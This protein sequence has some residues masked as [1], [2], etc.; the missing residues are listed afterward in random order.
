MSKQTIN[1]GASPNDGTGTPLRTS[2]D[3]TNQN[4]TELYTA[5]G[6]GVG[7]PGA[8]TQVI[9]NDGGTNLAGDAGL[10]YNK[11]TD[12]LTVAGLVTAGSATITGALTANG[13]VNLANAT[14][15]N[16][17]GL[18]TIYSD[19]AAGLFIRGRTV[20][21]T[22]FQTQDGTNPL[23]NIS[24]A[25][26]FTF[27][28]GA[29]GTRMT[30]NSTGLGIGGSPRTKFDV[31]LSGTANTGGSLA[32]SLGLFTGPG[33]VP[34]ID[35]SRAGANVNIESN[36][37]QGIDVG[38]SL[39]LGGRYTDSST[40][41]SGFAALF[42]AKSTATSNTISGYLAFYTSQ[43]AV[44][45]ERMRI[46]S[47]GNVGIGVTP[48]AWAST[49]KALNVST[50]AAFGGNSDDKLTLV[51]NNLYNDGSG[52]FIGNGYAASYDQ[53]QGA[54]R[55]KVS[56]TSNASGA[57]AALTLTQ[58]MTLDASGR[59]LV[60]STSA[61]TDLTGSKE[62]KIGDGGLQTFSSA[63]TAATATNIARSGFGALVHVAASNATG[64]YSAVVIFT[65]ASATVV[66]VINGTGSTITFGVASGFLQIT[67]SLA[68]TNLVASG[69]RNN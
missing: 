44:M 68:L 52:K 42:G 39:M 29:G 26:V 31:L 58:S 11:T 30:L 21:G 43:S 19:T 37:A 22:T 38:A 50:Y 47:S 15:V 35:G 25:G 16:F 17:G 32:P 10:V 6:G 63:I 3:Y 45:N 36:T 2:F 49:F 34:L 69:L 54:H 20:T 13:G 48:S 12:A 9:F 56:T 46:D 5:L 66:S 57:G 23:L 59:L 53:Y 24:N 1:I 18:L 8:T 62:V 27:S 4:F 28:D 55:W 64:Q 40:V 67:S 7:L 14:A 41:S 65:S 61:F 60:G 51:A 33:L